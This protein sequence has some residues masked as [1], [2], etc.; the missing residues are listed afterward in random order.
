MATP[1]Q[2]QADARRKYNATGDTFFVDDDFYDLI[3]EAET[4]LAEEALVIEK[5]YES[6]SVANQRAYA[7]P[8]LAMAIKRIEYDGSKLIYSTFRQDDQE[9]I[10]TTDTTSSGTPT[11][12]QLWER[13]F[14]L[15][16]IPDTSAL[17]I[18]VFTY[19]RPN[20]QS[21]PTSNLDT[22]EH[23]RKDIVTYC[24]ANMAMKDGNTAV[25]QQYFNRWDLAVKRAIRWQAKSRGVDGPKRVKNVDELPQSYS[26][27]LI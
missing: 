3:Y 19:D 15:R 23:Y 9:T 16:V 13:N 20:L 8:T 5:M 1:S 12:Y 10:S 24:V 11:I 26:Y 27:G 25:G 18:K 17:V 4:I 14:Y 7:W 2:V 22:P 6:T 21:S